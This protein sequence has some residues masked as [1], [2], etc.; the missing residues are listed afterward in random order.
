MKT[1]HNIRLTSAEL[2]NLWSSY[3]SDS[4]AICVLKYFIEKVEDTEIEQVLEYALHLSQRHVQRISEIFASEDHPI[5]HGF[6][7]EDVNIKAPRLFSDTYFLHYLKHMS[8]VGLN[9]QSLAIALAARS[10]I[11]DFHNESLASAA[12][13]NHKVTQVL[14]SKGLYIRP[15]YISIPQKV[16]Y[17]KKEG[18]LGHLMGDQRPLLAVEISH[19]YANLQT[20]SI[21]K[22]LVTGFSQVAQSKEVRKYMFRGKDIAKKHIEI[23]GKV[24]TDGD[25][26]APMTWD[27]DILDST[28]A[29]FSDKLMMFH[30]G[31]LN[32]VGIA[33]YGASTAISLR[34]DLGIIYSRLAAE[35]GLYANDGAKIMIDHGWMEQ[36]PQADDRKA[37][38]RI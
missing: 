24:L 9:A 36:P 22:A 34:K 3:M 25:L 33:D 11:L 20:N 26:P 14:L 19:L 38:A 12:E 7:D 18:F 28:V 37:L 1:D 5:P 4:M 15:P 6:T 17:V 23:L 8:R 30:T 16:Q 32:S 31:A 13:L 10:D 29:P 21:G 27:S 2:A 35:A